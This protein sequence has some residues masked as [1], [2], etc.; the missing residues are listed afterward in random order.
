MSEVPLYVAC[1][2]S[3]HSVVQFSPHAV[4]Q[5]NHNLKDLEVK[6]NILGWLLAVRGLVMYRGTLPIKQRPPP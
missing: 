6:C 4:A 3:P 5:R 1:G 2:V